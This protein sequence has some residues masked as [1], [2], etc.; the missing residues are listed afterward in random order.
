MIVQQLWTQGHLCWKVQRY[1]QMLVDV[2]C[3][4]ILF[5]TKVL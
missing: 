2:G 4:T 1:E 3:Y 5:L